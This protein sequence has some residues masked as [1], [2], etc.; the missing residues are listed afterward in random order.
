MWKKL[1][2]KIAGVAFTWG[3]KKLTEEVQPTTPSPS[4]KVRLRKP[5]TH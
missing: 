2:K 4:K 5:Y 1:L 3:L